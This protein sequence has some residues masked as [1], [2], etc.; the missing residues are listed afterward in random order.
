MQFDT[1]DQF[2]EVIHV[3]RSRMSESIPQHKQACLYMTHVV[4]NLPEYRMPIA[5]W[6]D[7]LYYGDMQLA[8]RHGDEES[9]G[10]RDA[11]ARLAVDLF[12]V[13]AFVHLVPHLTKI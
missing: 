2:W 6:N 12:W 4:A 5:T 10:C 11:S 9:A 7:I 8:K 1:D 3:I 13:G